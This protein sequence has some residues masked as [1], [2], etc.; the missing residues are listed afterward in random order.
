MNCKQSM[1][2]LAAF[3]LLTAAYSAAASDKLAGI[4]QKHTDQGIECASCHQQDNN[5]MIANTTCLECHDSF[6]TIAEQTSGMHLNP[7][8]SPHF[9]NLECTSCHVGHK[10]D[11]NF[12]QDC[13]GPIKRHKKS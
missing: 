4:A 2:S 8:Q 6:A 7:H 3:M 1:A 5:K 12:C 11:V 10:A 13:H 9:L